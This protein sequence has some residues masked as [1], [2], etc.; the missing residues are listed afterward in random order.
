MNFYANNENAI[1]WLQGN[2]RITVTLSDQHFWA[3]VRR[4]AKKHPDKV[5]ILA[6]PKDNGGYMYARLPLAFLQ[7]RDTGSRPEATDEQREFA[8]KIAEKGRAVIAAGS[9]STSN[10]SEPKRPSNGE[11]V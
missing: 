11:E 5:E 8:R 1:E 9:T 3:V 2:D 4:L 10:P 6:Q 7:I